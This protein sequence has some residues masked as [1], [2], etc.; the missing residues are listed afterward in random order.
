MTF[1]NNAMQMHQNKT[2]EAVIHST[3]QL[4]GETCLSVASM[5][6][7]VNHADVLAKSYLNLDIVR[8][9]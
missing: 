5:H 4:I 1:E 2:I 3:P 6:C 8:Q 9:S 7:E